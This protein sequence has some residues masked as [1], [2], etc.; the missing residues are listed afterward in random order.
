[1]HKWKSLLR[2]EKTVTYQL[3]LDIELDAAVVRK[4]DVVAVVAE[5]EILD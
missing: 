1:M 4:E 3:Y 5:A 2:T